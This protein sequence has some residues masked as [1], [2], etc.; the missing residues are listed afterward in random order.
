MPRRHISPYPI[1]NGAGSLSHPRRGGTPERLGHAPAYRYGP[2]LA[3][4]WACRPCRANHAPFGGGG[5]PCKS[6][7]GLGFAG[8]NGGRARGAGVPLG[9]A[10]RSYRKVQGEPCASR[11]RESGIRNPERMCPIQRPAD[12]GLF[13]G[14]RGHVAQA[15]AR[16]A[17]A[18]SSPLEGSM[19]QRAGGRSSTVRQGRTAWGGALAKPLFRHAPEGAF[20]S[21]STRDGAALALTSRLPGMGC[22]CPSR[23][24]VAW[25]TGVPHA[26]PLQAGACR[27][28]DARCRG[29]CLCNPSLFQ[30]EGTAWGGRRT[31][32]RG[33]GAGHRCGGRMLLVARL[34]ALAPKEGAWA[35]KAERA[36]SLAFLLW[37]D[38]R[39][40]WE[41][42]FFATWAGG[43][44][45]SQRLGLAA[46]VVARAGRGIAWRA[47]Q[48]A[49]HPGIWQGV[50]VRLRCG[51]AR[52]GRAGRDCVPRGRAAKRGRAEKPFS[53]L[54]ARRY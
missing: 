2:A 13:S 20:A 37:R 9:Y 45:F 51:F 29:A 11:C 15:K 14:L 48:A 6:S 26:W 3:G 35:T 7:A 47:V 12:R 24:G 52:M 18:R 41:L 44:A 53:G 22:S 32:A 46:M 23:A 33:R 43:S 25:A 17:E 36:A 5:T 30:P 1:R 31:F 49:L 27:T 34:P 10:G 40:P 21:P 8:G 38:Q 16:D 54:P 50:V 19:A 28:Q 42:A 4:W 39:G